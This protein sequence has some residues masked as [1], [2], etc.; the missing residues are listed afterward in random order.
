MFDSNAT[1]QKKRSPTQFLKKEKKVNTPNLSP[2]SHCFQKQKTHFP[3]NAISELKTAKKETLT[4]EIMR[5]AI[6][7][8]KNAHLFQLHT[9]KR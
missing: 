8:M 7:V 2:F 3:P 9:I 4:M 1:I 5:E 6:E